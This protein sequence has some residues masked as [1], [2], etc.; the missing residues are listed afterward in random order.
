MHAIQ[1]AVAV[2]RE[3]QKR[4]QR[5]LS[6]IKRHRAG[7]DN[8][9][10]A[11]QVSLFE[12][13]DDLPKAP[14]AES[15]LTA[16]HLGVVFILMG[17]LMVFS[18][19]ITSSYVEADW[20]RLL[21]VGTTFIIIGL[22]MVMVNRIITQREEEELTK[23]V[24]NRL[25]RTRSGYAIGRDLEANDDRRHMLRAKRLAAAGQP[26]GGGSS[27]RRQ[28][29]P[30]RNNTL[31]VH[32]NASVRSNSR[33]ASVRSG[34]SRAPS[35]RSTTNLSRAHTPLPPGSPAPPA[36]ATASAISEVKNGAVKDRRASTAATS[37]D[38]DPPH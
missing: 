36:P 38:L 15:S 12:E 27:I 7:D 34:C 35:I 14:K 11:S 29:R 28:Q 24:S 23:Y 2:R 1:G 31:T 5:R 10:N 8:I 16:F 32:R 13:D 26:G 37:T 22:I 33:R 18:S 21:G 3:R 19:M 9:S 30:S 4:Q 17:F 6:Q 20:S 25:A